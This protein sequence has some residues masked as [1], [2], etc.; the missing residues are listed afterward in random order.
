MGYSHYWRR[1]E[2]LNKQGFAKAVEEIKLV[3]ERVREIGVTICGP[4]GSGKAELSEFTV[5]FNGCTKCGHRFRDIGK[6]WPTADAEG[7]MEVDDPIARDAEPAFA[8]AY[9][10]TRTCGGNCAQEEFVVD[11]DWLHA[12]WHRTDRGMYPQQCET[13]FKPYDLVVTAALLR[14]K[15]NLGEE[16]VISSDG[17]EKAFQDAKRLCRQLFG[18]PSRFELESRS[19]AFSAT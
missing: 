10:K 19:P 13:R 17:D 3:I 4:T 16:I 7:V 5:A 15:E 18:W 14:L 8:G 2:H 12:D 9:V 11:R 1:A 6:P